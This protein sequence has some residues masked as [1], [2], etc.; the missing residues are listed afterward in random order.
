VHLRDGELP[1]GRLVVSVS[2]HTTA[3]IDGI[4]RDNHDPSR[5]GMRCVYGYFCEL[6]VVGAEIAVGREARI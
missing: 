2:K 6:A 4:I 3:V 5:S 1:M